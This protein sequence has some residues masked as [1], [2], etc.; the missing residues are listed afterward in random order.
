MQPTY[1]YTNAAIDAVAQ[2]VLHQTLQSTVHYQDCV[3]FTAL[4]STVKLKSDLSSE[5]I[6]RIA[7]AVTLELVDTI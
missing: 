2:I 3:M 4:V 1:W 7:T 6:A 5:E